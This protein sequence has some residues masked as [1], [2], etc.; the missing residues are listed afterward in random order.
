MKTSA[1]AKKTA[2]A[3]KANS[4]VPMHGAGRAPTVLC[5]SYFCSFVNSFFFLH[6]LIIFLLSFFRKTQRRGEKICQSSLQEK[7]ESRGS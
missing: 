4:L 1:A 5:L 6:S 3:T 7:S 2:K